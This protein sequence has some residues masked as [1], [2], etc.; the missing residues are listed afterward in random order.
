MKRLWLVVSLVFAVTALS[1]P[2][3]RV[4]AQDMPAEKSKCPFEGKKECMHKKFYEKLGLTDQQKQAWEKNKAAQHK[5]MKELFTAMKEKRNSLKEEL[6]KDKLN[7]G[8]VNRLNGELKKLVAR[9]LDLRLQNILAAK[10]ILTTEQFK[11]LLAKKDNRQGRHFGKGK[12]MG[13]HSCAMTNQKEL[14]TDKGAGA[15]A[16]KEDAASQ[17]QGEFQ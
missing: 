15:P 12:M 5:E 16:E 8:K 2:S 3:M 11:Q 13:R 17:P 1:A 7:M 14:D 10:K 9:S 4:Y 6:G